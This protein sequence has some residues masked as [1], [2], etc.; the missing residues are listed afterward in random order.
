MWEERTH[1]Q[2]CS[3]GSTALPAHSYHPWGGGL[4][5]SPGKATQR[6]APWRC[7][8]SSVSQLLCTITGLCVFSDCLQTADSDHSSPIP[9]SN[10]FPLSTWKLFSRLYHSFYLVAIVQ[11]NWTGINSLNQAT[12][13]ASIKPETNS[14][15]PRSR[16]LVAKWDRGF[17]FTLMYPPPA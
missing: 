9:T 15:P 5:H 13:P 8:E 17:L 2:C 10:I 16:S 6:K 3:F 12:M 7:Q 11:Q 14:R 4:C 1:C